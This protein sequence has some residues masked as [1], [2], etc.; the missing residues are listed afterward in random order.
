MGMVTYW[1]EQLQVKGNNMV[2][3]IIQLSIYQIS[4]PYILQGARGQ[5]LYLASICHKKGDHWWRYLV[6]PHVEIIYQH[7]AFPVK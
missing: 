6:V 3:L 2:L 1:Q 4:V 7:L 5:K